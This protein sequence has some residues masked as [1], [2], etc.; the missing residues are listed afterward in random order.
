VHEQA[1]AG[2]RIRLESLACEVGVD[3]I[4]RGGL[5]DVART[6]P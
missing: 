3:E 1:G 5:E 4:Y 2:G 6:E